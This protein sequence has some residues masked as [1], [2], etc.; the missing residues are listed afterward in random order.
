MWGPV[1]RGKGCRHRT[2]WERGTLGKPAHRRPSERAPSPAV[3]TKRTCSNGPGHEENKALACWQGCQQP[4]S[5]S[6]L[7]NRKTAWPS[8]GRVAVSVKLSTQRRRPSPHARRRCHFYVSGGLCVTETLML[9]PTHPLKSCP[10]EESASSLEF[11]FIFTSDNHPAALAASTMSV[12]SDACIHASW[13]VDDCPESCCE[14]CGA[15][16]C[17]QPRGCAPAPCL[18]FLCSPAGCASSPCCQSVCASCCTPSCCQPSSC[19]PCCCPCSAGQPSCCV[20]VCCKPVCCEPVCCRPVCCRPIPMCCEPVCC[21]ASS[22]CCQPSSCQPCCRPCPSCPLSSSVSLLCR[23]VCRPACCVPT[24][25]CCAPCCQPGCCRPAA[26]CVS[27]LCR[28]ACSRQACC[29]GSPGQ[30]SC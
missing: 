3:R 26:S 16:S 9:P 22:C 4:D 11:S 20:P 1:E 23:P 5:R 17:C 27:L 7:D 30:C 6:L 10:L 13:Q 8:G 21:G 29:G 14:P 12:C 28:P 24:S 2:F 19:Q 25:S 18:T 15:P